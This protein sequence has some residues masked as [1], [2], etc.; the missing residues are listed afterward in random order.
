MPTTEATETFPL[1]P[2]EV[3]ERV[4]DMS[5]LSEWDPMFDRSER[6]DEGPIEEGSRFRAEGSALGLEVDLVLTVV[7]H[8]PPRRIILE[9]RGDGIWTTEDIEIIPREDGTASELTYWS[10]FETDRSAILE[11]LA[12]PAF[13]VAGRRTMAGLRRW[14]T[15]P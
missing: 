13:T 12:Q 15:S 10:S 6:L 7:T 11:A 9:G 3:F 2:H 4:A 5:H 8:E 14:L 1:P